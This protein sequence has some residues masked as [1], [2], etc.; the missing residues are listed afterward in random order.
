MAPILKIISIPLMFL[1]VCLVAF[2]PDG[3]KIKEKHSKNLSDSVMYYQIQTTINYE[4]LKLKANEAKQ[5]FQSQNLGLSEV[6]R[7][8]RI[9]GNT[10][11]S[12]SNLRESTI[13]NRR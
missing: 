13:P 11:I 2:T 12:P 3:K 5:I 9:G 6:G 10:S 4:L 8:G 7:S 1:F